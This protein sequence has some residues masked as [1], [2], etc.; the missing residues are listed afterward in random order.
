MHPKFAQQSVAWV[1]EFPADPFGS[2]FREVSLLGKGWHCLD[3]RSRVF[4]GG[5][6]SAPPHP[7]CLCCNCSG[8]RAKPLLQ[9]WKLH[10]CPFVPCF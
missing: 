5:V 8:L 2:R 3:S 1:V 6:V 7:R 10:C 4:L 9:F